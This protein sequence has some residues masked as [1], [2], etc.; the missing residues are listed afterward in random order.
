MIESRST[1]P[2]MG[3]VVQTGESAS[4]TMVAKDWEALLAVANASAATEM[5]VEDECGALL[6]GRLAQNRYWS[7]T[8]AK[9]LAQHLIWSRLDLLKWHRRG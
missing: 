2:W 6:V 4:E 5:M 7:N 1:S 3:F 8:Q 9:L